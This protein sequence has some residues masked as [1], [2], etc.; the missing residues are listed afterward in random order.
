MSDITTDEHVELDEWIA[1]LKAKKASKRD[2][3]LSALAKAADAKAVQPILALL[4]Q[5]ENENTRMAAARALGAIGD[6]SA[7]IPLLEHLQKEEKR[8]VRKLIYRAF[9]EIGHPDA[10]PA[11]RNV[12]LKNRDYGERYAA[13][14]ALA[15]FE[16]P[17]AVDALRQAL[18]DNSL[19]ENLRGRIVN[20]LGEMQAKE[21]IAAIKE[22]LLNTSSDSVGRAAVSALIAI[23]GDEAVEFLAQ[24]LQEE[25]GD[26]PKVQQ[27]ILQQF[28]ELQSPQ[29]IP[30]LCRALLAL[31][32]S[33]AL[34]AEAR[35]ALLRAPAQWQEK[36]RQLVMILDADQTITASNMRWINSS[37]VQAV[38]PPAERLQTEPYLLVDHLAGYGRQYRDDE[39]MTE[40][41]ATLALASANDDRK[42]AGDRINAAFIAYVHRVLQISHTYSFYYLKQQLTFTE[43]TQSSDLIQSAMSDTIK[44][45]GSLPDA[46]SERVIRESLDRL[47][48]Q[49]EPAIERA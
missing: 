38:Q 47:R 21:A 20:L 9:G 43:M 7:V 2:E 23:Q 15:R 39:R 14:E 35:A 48:D 25:A 32:R 31:R 28:G 41:L 13:C 11:L 34:V 22:S 27:R 18:A 42:I 1:Q 5:E 30:H 8:A 29:V 16:G 45:L 10:V 6:P 19:S 46:E 12:L 33:P 44:A 36:A 49:V 17:E 24:L 26:R 40:V 4:H 3:A 37:I